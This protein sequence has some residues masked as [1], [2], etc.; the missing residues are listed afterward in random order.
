MSSS[1]SSSDD[2]DEGATPVAAKPCIQKLRETPIARL[3]TYLRI[4]NMINALLVLVVFPLGFI[5]EALTLQIS[6]AFFTGY[7]IIFA[8]IIFVFECNCGSWQVR[9]RTNFGFLCVLC[10][11]DRLIGKSSRYSRCC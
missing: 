11:S 7:S 10:I 1:S 6:T 8:V 5:T 2:E 3:L 9:I 4:T